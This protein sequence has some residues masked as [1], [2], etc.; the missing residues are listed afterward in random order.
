MEQKSEVQSH[1]QVPEI[2]NINCNWFFYIF[3]QW[4]WHMINNILKQ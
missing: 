4:V 1:S 2:T 3:L